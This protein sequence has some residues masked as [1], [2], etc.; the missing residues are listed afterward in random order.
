MAVA[1]VVFLIL[2][3]ATPAKAQ[4]T[5]TVTDLGAVAG[6]F[7]TV[8]NGINNRGEVAAVSFVSFFPLETI[9]FV[10]TKDGKMLLLPTLGGQ[11]SLPSAINNRGE[12]AGSANFAGDTITHAALWDGDL[13]Q[14][15]DLGTLGGATSDALWL[16]DKLEVVG[17]S[18]IANGTDTHAFLWKNGKMLDLGTLGGS[19]SLAFVNNEGGQIVGQSDITTAIDPTFGIPQFHGFLW[20]RGIIK[21][22]GEVFGG[23][24]NDATGIN[25]RGQIVGGAD[26]A[27]DLIGHAFSIEGGSIKD[28]GA[29]PGDNNSGAANLNN[30]GQVVGISASVVPGL[31]PVSGFECPC[32]AT[33]WEDGK[34]TDLNTVIPANSGWQLQF[35]IAVNDQ[36]QIV[37]VGARRTDFDIHAF[38]LTP[39]DAAAAS[40]PAAAAN[41]NS[42]MDWSQA[43]ATRIL[44]VNGKPRVVRER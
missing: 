11:S 26:L 25:D 13:S 12:V 33:I 14:V 10:V 4:R 39:H 27:G 28:L 17:D 30:L 42:S 16:N 22:F 37:G 8:P 38:L 31:P 43:S 29:L 21:D 7:E 20:E 2:T 3:W 19:N 18:I 36:G 15:T 35:A 40:T 41:F 9:G 1:T 6:A 34:A 23:H 44:M 5:Y 24:F 32:R